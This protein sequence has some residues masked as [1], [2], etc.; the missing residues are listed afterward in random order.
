MTCPDRLVLL[1]VYP[2]IQ[3]LD[4]VGPAEV[5]ALAT[6]G[7]RGRGY[8]LLVASPD[9]ESVRSDS[10]LRLEVDAGL[11]DVDDPVDTLI[12][13]GGFGFDAATT[14]ELLD[15]V[16]SLARRARRVCS[17]CSGAFLLAAAGLL[18]GRSA[19]THWL[20]CGELARRYPE[21]TVEPD[22]IFVRDGDVYTSAGVTA[23]IDLALALVEADHGTEVARSVAR[24]LVVF[25][26]RPGGQSQF[27]ARLD[28]GVTAD[29]P[30]RPVLDAI[31]ADPAA[32][33][34][35]PRLA[36]R[37][38]MSERHLGRLFGEQTGTTPARFVERVR[39]EAARDLLER[40]ALPVE[41]VSQRSGFRS[42]ETMRR[43]FLRVLGVAPSD[44]RDRFQSAH[45]SPEVR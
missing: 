26:Q 34:S 7:L 32:D 33:H 14:P 16:G 15:A 8:R 23:G 17:V 30:L 10:G 24:G 2:G 31:T 11:S 39:V 44:Y 29:S 35:V 20:V 45:P 18:A 4:A 12:V 6:V 3:M 13:A 38:H 9:G 36:E 1:V 43:A 41:G 21:I 5:F 37:A 27:S 25:L 28:H 42:D 40:S 19:T 22:R